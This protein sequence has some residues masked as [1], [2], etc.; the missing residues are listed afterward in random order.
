MKLRIAEKFTA[1]WWQF[2]HYKSAASQPKM[3]IVIEFGNH[4]LK[5][6]LFL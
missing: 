4:E 6:D 5:V 3:T 2:C 1:E